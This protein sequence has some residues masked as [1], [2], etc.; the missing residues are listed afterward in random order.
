MILSKSTSL[1]AW[2]LIDQLGDAC[3]IAKC[4]VGKLKVVAFQTTGQVFVH[5]V[6]SGYTHGLAVSQVNREIG[7]AMLSFSG[8]PHQFVAVG[9]NGM[10]GTHIISPPDV[11]V[12]SLGQPNGEPTRDSEL[13]LLLFAEVE[14]GN[15]SLPELIHHLGMPLANYPNLDGVLGIKGEQDDNG[16]QMNALVLITI[17]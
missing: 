8:Q 7:N 1:V 16:N 11:T 17:L 5:Q 15:H 10:Y 6:A 2:L 3:S 12:Q 4:S 13:G 9:T 14:S